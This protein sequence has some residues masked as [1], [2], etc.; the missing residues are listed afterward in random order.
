M[1]MDEEERRRE[2]GVSRALTKKLERT[3]GEE[4][5]KAEEDEKPPKSSKQTQGQRQGASMGR[6]EQW[7]DTHQKWHTTGS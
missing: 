5:E 6:T 3:M 1:Q 7:Q 4:G 2:R